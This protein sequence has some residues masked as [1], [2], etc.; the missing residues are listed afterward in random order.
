M[1]IKISKG[2][3][4]I[5]KIP[6]ISLVPIK[7]CGNCSYCREKCY[8]RKAYRQYPNVRKN[9]DANSEAFR[10]NVVEAMIMVSDYLTRHPTDYFRIFVA[11][12]FLN[13][14]NV[15]AWSTLCMMHSK[16]DFMVNTKMFNL[17]YSYIPNNM[18]LRFSMW[19][20]Q[21]NPNIKMARAWVQ[22]GTE[23]RIP[24]DAIDCSGS[25]EECLICYTTNNDVVFK[26]N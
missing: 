15:N 9:W 24:A 21:P 12:D 13:Q 6:N 16:T 26:I 25:C 23:M 17:D 18:H 2:N 5:G 20:G 8:A 4:K 3:S 1:Q 22:D 7:D 10:E 11:G 19:P 14:Q